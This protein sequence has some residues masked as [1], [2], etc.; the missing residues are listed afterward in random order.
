MLGDEILHFIRSRRSVR[1]FQPKAVPA[2][3]LED[4]LET[5]LWAPSAHNCQ[6]WR[7]AIVHSAEPKARLA[8]LMGAEFRR[9]LQRDGLPST[10]IDLRITRSRQRIQQAPVL[11]LLCL[12]PTGL[13][14]YPDLTRNQA[15]HTMAVQSVAMA[16]ACLMLA[17]HAHGLGTVW[18]CAP[19]FAPAAVLQALDL[20]Q[21]WQPQGMLL[22]GYPGRISPHLAPHLAPHVAPHPALPRARRPLAEVARYF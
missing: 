20:P 18:M 8:E 11:I 1:R 6:P 12:D 2:A 5:A 13:D 16:G 15:E 22:A 10:E 21:D 14:T 9:D 3:L 4:I 17:A 19:L 7:F